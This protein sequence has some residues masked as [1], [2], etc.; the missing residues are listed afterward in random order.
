[1]KYESAVENGATRTLVAG[2][3]EAATYRIELPASKRVMDLLI[4]VPVLFFLS[5][6]MLL[7]GVLIKIQDGGSMFFVQ[8]RRGHQGKYFLCMKFRTMRP[9]AEEILR[10]ILATDP[11]MAAEWKE[12]Q[13]FRKD[14][15]ITS[16]GQFLRR[17]SLDELPQLMNIL[18][19][20]MSIVG[21][22][23]IVEDE[24]ERYGD[25]IEAYDSVRP[26]VTG[27]WQV[28]GRS[29]TSYDERVALDTTYAKNVSVTGDIG[30]LLRTIPA[31]LFARGAI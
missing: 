3:S 20:E 25:Q 26:G 9:D 24:V 5:P 8:R 15:R 28:S 30:I 31:V 29:D 12:N 21:P 14:P 10:L 7:I 27:L 13:K 4:A 18:R 19:G 6:I 17:T 16:L 22:R 1:M 11:E 23:P 2:E